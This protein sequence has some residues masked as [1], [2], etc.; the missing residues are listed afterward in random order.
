MK[1][2]QILEL[3]EK[4]SD[5]YGLSKPYLCGGLPRDKYLGKIPSIADIDITTGDKTIQKLSNECFDILNKKFNIIKSTK[6]DGHTT[7]YFKNIKIDFSSNYIDPNVKK[8]LNDI[9][10]KNPTEIELE[11]FS[12]DFGCNS[13]LLSFDLK[14]LLDPTNS[15]KKDCDNKIIK[16]IMPPEFTFKPSPV[17]GKN[18]RVVRS[19][20]LASKLGFTIDDKI[21]S[22]VSKNPASFAL[23]DEKT[24]AK[25]LNK[26]YELDSDRAI[27]YLNKM[28]LWNYIPINDMF[29]DEVLNLLANRVNYEK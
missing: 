27:Y 6:Q 14:Q 8:Y 2:R 22:Y 10:N 3:I 7:F 12:R 9:G 11:S 28:N 5:K 17:T 24:I 16:T 15:G 25:K 18:N 19:I 29:S 20:Y 23:A 1:L 4:V 26:A 21:I 13:M